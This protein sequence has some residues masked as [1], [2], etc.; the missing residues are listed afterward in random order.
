MGLDVTSYEKVEL[1]DPQP[2]DGYGGNAA[3][4]E[5]AGFP[6]TFG[7]VLQPGK[8]YRTEGRNSFRAG[9]Y[10]YYNRFRQFLWSCVSGDSIEL[11]WSEPAKYAD[12]PFALLCNF[13]DC[14]G[15]I[16][17]DVAQVLAREFTEHQKS[18]H[19]TA[20]LAD[21]PDFVRLYD[22][23]LAAFSAAAD[24]GAVRFC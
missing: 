21:E 15:C 2:A 12:K 20:L 18:F 7:E 13:S 22:Q 17:P 14:D 19:Q 5:P 24:T 10:S 6:A 23:F 16:G 8:W 3:Q 1:L 4:L 9:S 11:L